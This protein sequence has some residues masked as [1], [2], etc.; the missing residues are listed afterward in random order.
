MNLQE[1]KQEVIYQGIN[2]DVSKMKKQDIAQLLRNHKSG[3]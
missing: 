1:L 2:V 3:V